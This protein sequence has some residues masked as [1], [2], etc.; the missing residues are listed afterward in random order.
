MKKR[1]NRPIDPTVLG[2]VKFD[3]ELDATALDTP[4]RILEYFRSKNFIANGCTSIEE[5]IRQNPELELV[6]E[7][8]G[9]ADAY[10]M[11][12]GE[13]HFRIA[14]NSRHHKNRQRFSMAHEYAHYQLHREQI[15]S[16]PEGE[17]I[18]YRNAERNLTEYQANRIAS[19]ILMPEAEFVDCIKRLS[20]D[21]RAISTIFQ[22][23][24]EA[25]RVR[26]SQLGWNML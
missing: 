22:V 6:F 16:K 9:D 5:A 11:K 17:R 18:L 14:V 23:S 12:V 8:L 21:V 24:P 3:T 1:P 26:A 15:G 25:V 13:G 10:I 4:E 19:E 2:T 20:G 7:D